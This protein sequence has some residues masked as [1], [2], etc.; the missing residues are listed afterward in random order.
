MTKEIP[1][2]FSTDDNY[3]PYLDIAI[4]SLIA[5]ASKQYKYRIIVLNTGLKE[6]S[7]RNVMKNETENFKI[8][9]VD[10]SAEVEAIKSRF[11]NVY[12]FSVVTY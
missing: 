2:F 8:D 12:H 4:R 6:D 11:K 3:V 7:V 5:H 10:I 1:I 9:F